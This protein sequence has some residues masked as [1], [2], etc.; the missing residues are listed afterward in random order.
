MNTAQNTDERI[1][2]LQVYR[3]ECM[4]QQEGLKRTG[5]ITK[6]LQL[7][8]P[9]LCHQNKLEGRTL[10]G[11][12]EVRDNGGAD[13]EQNSQMFLQIH[14][15]KFGASDDVESRAAGKK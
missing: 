1:L 7:D 4:I 9:A 2:T 13:G 14:G 11:L 5:R 12:T 3:V 15:P 8:Q 10:S 6:L